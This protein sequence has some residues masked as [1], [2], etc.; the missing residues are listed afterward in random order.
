MRGCCTGLVKSYIIAS[1][2]TY[3]SVFLRKFVTTY[4]TRICHSEYGN[5]LQFLLGSVVLRSLS[6]RA[7]FVK[8]RLSCL[9]EASLLAAPKKLS[10]EYELTEFTSGAIGSRLPMRK[11][12]K[13][14]IGSGG[15][16]MASWKLP[17]FITPSTKGDKFVHCKLYRSHFSVAHGGFNDVTRH[18]EVLTHQQRLKDAQSTSMIASALFRSQAQADISPKVTSSEIM[19]TLLLCTTCH[20]KVQIISLT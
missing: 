15:K 19:M 3:Y 17:R 1:N 10:S 4:E 7:K 16:F 18:V 20:F 12:R 5:D 9:V 14:A 13:I 2:P 11:K 8:S 6:R